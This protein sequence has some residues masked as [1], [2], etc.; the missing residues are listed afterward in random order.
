MIP[1]AINQR[2][3]VNSVVSFGNPTG[4]LTGPVTSNVQSFES[5]YQQQNVNLKGV[6]ST[7]S[8]VNPTTYF[9][10]G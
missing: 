6:L 3:I 9:A 5:S 4:N 2:N 10:T 8:F 7:N 1:S